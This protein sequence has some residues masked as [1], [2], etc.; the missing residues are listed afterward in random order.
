MQR[1]SCGNDRHQR[2]N[3]LAET[4]I[5][6]LALAP[7]LAGIPLLGKQLD[8]KH[9]TFDAAR[10][11]VWERTVWRSDGFD[12]RKAPEQI[13]IEARERL[14][15]DPRVGIVAPETL[16]A[17]GVAENP[18]WRDRQRAPLLDYQRVPV[19]ATHE[20]RRTPADVGRLFAP[21]VAHGDGAVAAL[22]SLLQV[23]DLGL[24][25]RAFATASVNV[26][27]RPTLHLLA[28]RSPQLGTIAPAQ[29][30]EVL[31][32][33]ANGAVLSDSWSAASEAQLGQRVDEVTTDELIEMLELPAR[34][35][36]Q[37]ALGKG[38]PLY[39]EGQFAWDPDLR[40]RTTTLPAAYVTQ[41]R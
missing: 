4:V 17:E 14:L 12:N 37:Q 25:R 26:N 35:V 20:E 1:A 27:V 19:T 23:E 8:V 18:L 24:S 9:K 36:G 13:T 2:G 33:R 30:H 5:A 34:I 3:A 38:R 21:A 10:Y 28:D 16:Y 6:M 32:Q 29:Q 7:F 41:R 15:G 11:S 39:G 22:A 31:V 40:P